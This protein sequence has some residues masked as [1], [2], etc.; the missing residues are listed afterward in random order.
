MDAHGTSDAPGT[1]EGFAGAE[2]TASSQSDP[3]EDASQAQMGSGDLDAEETIEMLGRL[4]PEFGMLLILS[5]IAGVILPGPVGT[6]LLIAGGV[7]MWPKAFG[8]I[9]R[10]FSRKFPAVHREGVH[11]IREFVKDLQRRFPESK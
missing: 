6:P 3:T 2:R 11:Q 5:G 10:W 1:V 9:E 7:T 4:P 8:P